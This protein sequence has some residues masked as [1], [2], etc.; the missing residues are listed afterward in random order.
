MVFRQ[1]LCERSIH[2]IHP[3][4]SS[5]TKDAL[6]HVFVTMTKIIILDRYRPVST[7]FP[8]DLH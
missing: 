1:I 8:G 3:A 6:L 2:S 4:L 7:P 5:D